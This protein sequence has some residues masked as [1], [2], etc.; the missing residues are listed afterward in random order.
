M[1][2]KTQIIKTVIKCPDNMVV[3]F[4]KE[5]EQ[6]PEYQYHYEKV[7][8]RILEDAPPSAGFWYLANYSEPKLQRVARE[9]W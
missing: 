3:V 9:E 7:K 1:K 6:I 2:Q 4:D 5:G 8:E